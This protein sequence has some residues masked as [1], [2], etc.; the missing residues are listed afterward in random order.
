[1]WGFDPALRRSESG[2][3]APVDFAAEALAA[4]KPDNR[5]GMTP[6]FQVATSLR[7][8]DEP[9]D[10]WRKIGFTAHLIAPDGGFIVGQSALVSLSGAPPREALLR[11]PIAMH[12]SFHGLPGNDYPRALMGI[13]AH[14]RQTLLDAGYH[15]RMW[16]AFEQNGRMGRR[17]PL[18]PSLDALNL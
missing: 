11:S 3:P 14:C 8:E 5:K 13:I 6:E 4:T 16:A 7:V 1:T 18:D 12:L 2:P 17:P 15:Q 10:N 9:T